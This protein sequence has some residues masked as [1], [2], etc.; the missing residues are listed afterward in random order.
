MM[1]MR[2]SR[3]EHEEEEEKED[4]FGVLPHLQT[5]E[6]KSESKGIFNFSVDKVLTLLGLLPL[7]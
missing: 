2:S 1:I 7:S 4:I 3:N 5:Y 6:G